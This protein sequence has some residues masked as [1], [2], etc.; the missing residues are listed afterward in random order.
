M[1]V[2]LSDFKK[3][4]DLLY[5][6]IRSKKDSNT[7]DYTQILNHLQIAIDKALLEVV[8]IYKDESEIDRIFGRLKSRRD[9]FMNPHL[10]IKLPKVFE[11]EKDLK[12]KLIRYYESCF[13]VNHFH[14]IC[15]K[16]QFNQI[17]TEVLAAEGLSFNLE[18]DF[19]DFFNFIDRSIVFDD[20]NFVLSI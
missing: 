19:D 13:N 9:M 2:L 20:F 18:T 11:E 5:Q 12:V 4:G 1:W 17:I 15:R 8:K 16:P 3:F 14:K 6:Y 7:V 10:G